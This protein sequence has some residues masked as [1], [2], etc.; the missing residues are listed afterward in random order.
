MLSSSPSL[1]SQVPKFQFSARIVLEM[2]DEQLLVLLPGGRNDSEGGQI[3]FG[4]ADGR[5]DGSPDGR[6]VQQPF[7]LMMSSL[8]LRYSSP[9]LLSYY[10]YQCML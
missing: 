8:V 9:K 7:F 5:V 4:E 6:I 1:Y 3:V 10:L 2:C